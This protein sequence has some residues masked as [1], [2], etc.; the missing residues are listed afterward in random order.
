[1]KIAGTCCAKVPTDKI[2]TF[3]SFRGF[4]S[5]GAAC[6]KLVLTE[7]TAMTGYQSGPVGAVHDLELKRAGA[8]C[9]DKKFQHQ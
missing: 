5:S 8:K 6:R 2:N 1:L 9:I 3:T 4:K 7:V